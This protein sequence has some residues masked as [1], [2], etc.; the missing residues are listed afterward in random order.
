MRAASAAL[1]ARLEMALAAVL[2]HDEASDDKLFSGLERS[3]AQ[4][5]SIG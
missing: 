3:E 5:R 2:W 1:E 4:R